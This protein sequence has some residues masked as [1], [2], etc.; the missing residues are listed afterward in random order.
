MYKK[1]NDILY[2]N[3]GAFSKYA[4]DILRIADEKCVNSLHELVKIC[5]YSY[6]FVRKIFYVLDDRIQLDKDCFS[7]D[8]LRACMEKKEESMD[9]VS[10][11]LIGEMDI[12]I[13]QFNY[14]DAN[15]DHI[16][17]TAETCSKRAFYLYENFDAERINILFLGDHDLTSIAFA[18]LCSMKKKKCNIYVADIDNKIL[19]LISEKSK[20]L[21]VKIN[22]ANADFRYSVPVSY[23]DHMDVVFTDPP[24]TPEGM[25]VFLDAGIQCLKNNPFST[26]L[27]CYKTAEMSNKLGV[28]VQKELMKKKLYISS[29]YGNFNVY[30][31]AEA[32][33]YRSDLYVC[34]VTPDS[35]KALGNQNYYYN[36]YTHGTD[37]I[38]SIKDDKDYREIFEI[39]VKRAANDKKIY[40]ITREKMEKALQ[41][42]GIINISMDNFIRNKLSGK[43]NI[44]DNNMIV[45]DCSKD[46]LCYGF[47]TL[48]LMNY[49]SYYC[50]IQKKQENAFENSSVNNI[51][52]HFFDREVILKKSYIVYKYTRKCLSEERGEKILYQMFCSIRSSTINSFKKNASNIMGITKNEAKDMYYR[53]ELDFDEKLPLF[54]LGDADLNKLLSQVLI[55]E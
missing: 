4:Y 51:L 27:I 55:I 14:S 5:G 32:L 9:D 50:V 8:D 26:L 29:M 35:F 47:K 23:F 41:K 21:G 45:V 52:G 2:E 20:E 11:K 6:K 30:Y 54:Y 24:Y 43:S 19:S 42:Q 18:L 33:G 36:I 44:I 53:M 46:N 1:I 10:R 34:R 37:A 15:L 40:Y 3:F 16:S 12:I 13:K 25:G 22:L 28:L 38:E 48:L 49:N 7:L 17:A 31:Q 39:L